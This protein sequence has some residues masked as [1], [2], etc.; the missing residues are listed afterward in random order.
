MEGVRGTI[1]LVGL[2]Q[3]GAAV[4]LVKRGPG[5]RVSD[6]SNEIPVELVE[7]FVPNQAIRNVWTN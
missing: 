2:V 5:L 4:R 1:E 3:G 7:A 6:E